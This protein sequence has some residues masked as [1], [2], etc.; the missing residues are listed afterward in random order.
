MN[1][2]EVKKKLKE[3]LYRR[4]YEPLERYTKVEPI[5]SG[6]NR[7]FFRIIEKQ[8][9]S[10]LMIANVHR[11]VKEF[12]KLQEFLME[13]GIGVP[14]I[15]VADV[16]SYLV[17]MEDV[18]KKS[19]YNLTKEG[20]N[21]EFVE[22]LYKKVIKLLLHMQLSAT[23]GL[24]ECKHVYE[25]IFDY[26]SLRWESNY[27]KWFF[28][29][30][31]CKFSK[32][33]TEKLEDDFH[34]LASSLVDEPLFFMHRDFQSTNIFFKNGI[35]R[36]VDFQ[37]AHRGLLTYD[38]A[39]LLRDAYVTLS[40]E[41]RNRLFSYYYSLLR[42]KTDLYKDINEFRRI[43]VLSALQRNMQALG[44]FIYL[45]KIMRKRWFKK[46]IPRGL[47]YLKEGLEEI[48]EFGELS[49]IVNSK[50]VKRCVKSIG[51]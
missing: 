13:R 7:D 6:S 34:N 27:F 42:K 31:F 16:D 51:S 20:T 1:K 35:V 28:L 43:Y 45:W 22:H 41:M 15:I 44:A 50:K 23:E 30:E 9:T 29:E 19:L 8:Y 17:L 5:F 26:D 36:I 14:G 47:K 2:R 49:K 3:M 25:K 21:L 37:D 39:S 46:A 18:G 38:L 10:V 40:R 33:E 32:E 24:E 48:G 4:G 11:E 12:R